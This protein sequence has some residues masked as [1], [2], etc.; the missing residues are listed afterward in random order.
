MQRALA[1]IGKV[2]DALWDPVARAG[3]FV[4]SLVT[5][6]MVKLPP[7]FTNVELEKQVEGQPFHRAAGR[8]VK[9]AITD[10]IYFEIGVW[11]IGA[12]VIVLAVLIVLAILWLFGPLPPVHEWRSQ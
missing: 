11:A 2:I 4:L 9:L 7:N 10:Q 5:F 8:F 3:R 6:G 12:A 1:T